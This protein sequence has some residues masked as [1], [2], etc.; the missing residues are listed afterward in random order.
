MQTDDQTMPGPK[1]Q[2]C[3]EWV[4]IYNLLQNKVIGLQKY[5]VDNSRCIVFRGN[6]CLIVVGINEF[7]VFV[8]GYRVVNWNQYV[9]VHNS[10]IREKYMSISK[11]YGISKKFWRDTPA[12]LS[13]ESLANII[14]GM[15]ELL[16]THEYEIFNISI[17]KILPGAGGIPSAEY[18]N[19]S[20]IV[21]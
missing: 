17:T 20:S 15:N 7:R 2:L 6:D 18:F 19:I 13:V 8:A 1:E 3:K 12:H 14:Q 16:N 5:L 4:Q 11:A 21:K 9:I 10:S